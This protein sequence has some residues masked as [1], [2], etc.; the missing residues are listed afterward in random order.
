MV[1]RLLGLV[2]AAAVLLLL[3]FSFGQLSGEAA[4]SGPLHPDDTMRL[5]SE[6]NFS[7]KQATAEVLVRQ[8]ESE[9]LFGPQTKSRFAAA[10]GRQALARELSSELDAA[11]NPDVKAYVSPSESMA[12]VARRAVGLLN[13]DQ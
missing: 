10:G 3:A 5:W 11:A 7:Q 12:R 2:A 9:G 4:P 6:A 8:L 1:L 13:W